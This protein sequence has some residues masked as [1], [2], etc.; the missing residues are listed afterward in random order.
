MFQL[1]DMNNINVPCKRVILFDT[2]FEWRCALP[3]IYILHIGF[4]SAQIDNVLHCIEKRQFVCKCLKN[5]SNEKNRLHLG[6]CETSMSFFCITFLHIYLHLVLELSC[7]V[8]AQ[9]NI[10]YLLAFC[11]LIYWFFVVLYVYF[12][13][14]CI[15]VDTT[16]FQNRVKIYYAIGLIPF[17]TYFTA[18]FIIL[19]LYRK[20]VPF[21]IV[22]SFFNSYYSLF[23]FFFT[24]LK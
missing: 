8:C 4:F 18:S 1:I 11:L 5:C 12:Y 23:N 19:I 17:L 22:V 20:T 2:S 9:M 24:L 16:A 3:F 6:D 21:L 14:C 7:C 10:S 15:Q 13:Y